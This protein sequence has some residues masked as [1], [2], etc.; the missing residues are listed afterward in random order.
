MGTMRAISDQGLR[1][2]QDISVLGYF[3]VFQIVQMM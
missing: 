2:P 3:L 1:V